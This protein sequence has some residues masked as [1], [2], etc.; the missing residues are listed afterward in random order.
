KLLEGE[1]CRPIKVSVTKKTAARFEPV[2]FSE[3]YKV[4]GKYILL[5]EFPLTNFNAS[6]LLKNYIDTP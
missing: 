6:R 2:N 4:A 5:S 1:N 3:R